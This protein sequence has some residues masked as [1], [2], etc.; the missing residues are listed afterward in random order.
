MKLLIARRYV[1]VING[2]AFFLSRLGGHSL[3][4]GTSAH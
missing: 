3:V 2:E 4:L 1:D